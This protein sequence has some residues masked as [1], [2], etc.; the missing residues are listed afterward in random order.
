MRAGKWH[1]CPIVDDQPFLS[2][3]RKFMRIHSAIADMARAARPAEKALIKPWD[4]RIAIYCDHCGCDHC[5]C[6]R[7]MRRGVAS[8]QRRMSCTALRRQA[9]LRVVRP[10]VRNDRA[11]ASPQMATGFRHPFRIRLPD[12]SRHGPRQVGPSRSVTAGYWWSAWPSGRYWVR[13]PCR[14]APHRNSAGCRDCR[15]ST[16]G[17]RDR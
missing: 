8:G 10:S 13:N 16:A 11:G 15:Y 17:R 9:P 4:K 3:F 6:G 5:G 2:P 12:L 14:S 7:L 1:S